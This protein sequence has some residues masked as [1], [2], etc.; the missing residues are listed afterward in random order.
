MEETTM[1]T[2]QK[3]EDFKSRTLVKDRQNRVGVVVS[4]SLESDKIVLV[5]FDGCLE[6]EE[7]NWEE[8]AI[9]GR[10]K[11][12]FMVACAKC[13]FRSGTKVCRRY[14]HPSSIFVP[15]DGQRKPVRIYPHCQQF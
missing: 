5:E 1:A 13:V 14:W 6:T 4:L 2:A 15:V 7:V 8:L 3:R 12:D 11:I 10:L 9:T